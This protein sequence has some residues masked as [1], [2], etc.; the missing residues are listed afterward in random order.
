M[1]APLTRKLLRDV[2]QAK[3]QTL[4]IVMVLA[5]GVAMFVAYLSAFSSLELTRDRFYHQA[6]F[7]HVF[8]GL[9]RAPEAL[10]ERLQALPGVA[11]VETR[12]VA[13]AALDLPQLAGPASARLVSIPVPGSPA[14]NAL[15]LRRGRYPFPG[16]FDEVLISEAFAIANGLGPGSAIAALVNGRRRSFHVV[17][18]A[19]SPEYV[20]V[21]RSGDVIPDDRSFG[22]F[23][24]DRTT[25]AAA[26]DQDASFNDVV[27][28][29]ST[30]AREAAVIAALD[31]VLRPYGGRGAVGR[32]L[33]LSNWAVSNELEQ[34][35]GFGLFIPL[36]FLT[37]AAFLLNVVL[38]RTVG[39]Q[40]LQI[41]ALKALGYSGAAIGAHYAA[42]AVLIGVAGALLG[43]GG[44][45]WLGH[46]MMTMYNDFFRFP[47]LTHQVSAGVLAAALA[48]SIVAAM[49][50]ALAAVRSAVTLPPAVAMVPPAPPRYRPSLIE[51]IGPG[52]LL[53]PVGRMI[54]R[55]LERQPL[56]S[57]TSI[58]GVAS[59][60]ALLVLGLFF[61]DAIEAMIHRQFDV[62]DRF[63]VTL[64]FTEPRSPGAVHAL[65]RLPGV[66]AVEPARDV[67]VRV[68]NGHRARL[69]AI[70]A[71]PD[72][73]RLRRV[74]TAD[75]TPID[76]PAGG[77][78]LSRAL[79]DALGVGVSGSVDV[80]LLAGRQVTR[81]VPVVAMIDDYVG[82]AAYMQPDAVQEMA[83]EAETISGA[84]L[85]IDDLGREA[86]FDQLKRMPAVAD[87]VS[88]GAVYDSF[89]RTIDDT[90]GVMVGFNVLFATIIAVGVVYN[91]ARLSLSERSR[92]LASLRVIGFT[93]GEIAA[94]LLGELAVLTTA[95]IAA[96]CAIGYGLAAGVVAAFQ[97][98]MYRFPIVV[99][100]RTVRDGRLGHRP[101]RRGLGAAGTTTPEPPRP[102]RGAQDPGV[103]RVDTVSPPPP[104]HPSHQRGL[105]GRRSR[106]RV[107]PARA[108]AG[109]RRGRCAAS[110]GA[111]GDRARAG[112]DA[113]PR[114]LCGVGAAGGSRAAHRGPA[115]R[116]GRGRTHRTGH[117]DPD[118]SGTP[119]RPDP[120]RTAC[121]PGRC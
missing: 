87:V 112:R 78:V 106:T 50:G 77:L 4:A 20:Y 48:I 75:G 32:S 17:G 1:A 42:W 93:R 19:L 47:E 90:M 62:V 57:A 10:R 76:V 40:R 27:L 109:R 115:R 88:T 26:V 64:N 59:A 83:G 108:G 68:R 31:R 43:V 98:E 63:D 72:Q 86:L 36:V 33:Q 51:R 70:S 107:A 30:G 69:V 38:A 24:L 9:D 21:L 89:R 111:A 46:A 110:D 2:W 15:H 79:G 16:R 82:L 113:C 103:A 23:W 94:V 117:A 73:A 116:P 41:A 85:L 119:R 104:H 58:L 97:T 14:L 52:L 29:M 102:R 35:K 56:R 5:A 80:E 7:A 34:L 8:A 65:R 25:L 114:P 101:C 61:L 121:G 105:A 13:T 67:P 96:G 45:W 49:A 28:T 44:G 53:G 12:V 66:L 92:D 120:Q 60:T 18:I 74:V 84:R 39:M 6:R 95:G 11:V 71:I 91:A 3:A 100:S 37:V 22:V 99:S 55:N 118:G 81:R 54:G